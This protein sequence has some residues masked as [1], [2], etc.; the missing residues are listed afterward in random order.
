MLD[1]HIELFVR[2]KAG[3]TRHSGRTFFEHLMGTYDLLVAQGAPVY[4]CLAGLCH[5]IYGTNAFK[6]ASVPA[7]ER[8]SVIDAIGPKAERLAW[9]FCACRRPMALV[10]AFVSGEPYQVINRHSGEAIDLSRRELLDLLTI[11]VANLVE[12]DAVRSRVFPL[13][14][15][16]Q[17]AMREAADA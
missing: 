7:S 12:Q 17:Q 15:D 1:R 8:K 11:E 14:V 4:V 6:H 2:E 3:E 13:V 9:I 5:S 10:D 16:A